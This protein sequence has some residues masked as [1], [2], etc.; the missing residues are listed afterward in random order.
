MAFIKIDNEGRVTAASYNYHCGDDEIEV[1]IPEEIGNLSNIHNYKYIDGNF[2]YDPIPEVEE[3]DLP[4][5]LD[6]LDAR[7]TYIEMMTG[8]MEV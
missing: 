7:L 5:D 4:S 3:E 8:L 1:T 6:R 2:V